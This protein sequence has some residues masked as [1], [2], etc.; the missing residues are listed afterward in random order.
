MLLLKH[1]LEHPVCVAGRVVLAQ[2][3]HTLIT[4]VLP[5]GFLTQKLADML[6]SLVRVTRRAKQTL[7]VNQSTGCS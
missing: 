1:S 2:P 3:S 5:S 7:V 4:F 6:D